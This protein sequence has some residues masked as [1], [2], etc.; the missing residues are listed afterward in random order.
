MSCVFSLKWYVVCV[1]IF[2]IMVL[3]EIFYLGFFGLGE[4]V[5]LCGYVVC[6]GNGIFYFMVDWL[7]VVE[8]MC[9]NGV[10]GW[11]EIYGI[12]VFCVICEMVNDLLVFVVLGC[13]L[14][15]VVEL[16]DELYGFMWVCG[17]FGGYYVDVIVVL[18]I[19][20]WDLCVQLY[21]V[22]LCELFGLVYWEVVL[23]YLLG[24][25]GVMLKDCVE[26]V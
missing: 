7:V 15:D 2:I 4:V 14:E 21:G 16:W 17:S 9:D 26:M 19:V 18:D 20:L 22:F 10:V 24:L 23:G 6:C 8:V 13:V 11:G 12:C 3:C 5:N 25:L 1:C